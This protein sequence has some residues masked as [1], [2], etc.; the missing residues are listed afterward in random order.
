M[1]YLLLLEVSDD[2]H[3]RLPHPLNEMGL[4]NISMKENDETDKFSD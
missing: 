2:H 3:R 4:W 1:E